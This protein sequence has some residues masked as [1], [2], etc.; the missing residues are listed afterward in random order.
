MHGRAKPLFFPF[1]TDSATQ[2]QFLAFDYFME[3]ARFYRARG[4]E[5]QAS[6]LRTPIGF[7]VARSPRPEARSSKLVSAPFLMQIGKADRSHNRFLF[8]WLRLTR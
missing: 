3:R 8:V 7:W 4:L 2:V 5:N 6:E 1:F